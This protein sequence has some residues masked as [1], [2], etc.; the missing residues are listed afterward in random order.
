MHIPVDHWQTLDAHF[1]DKCVIKPLLSER[2]TGT[3][4]CQSLLRHACCFD[5]TSLL[6]GTRR[7][8]VKTAR[9]RQFRLLTRLFENIGAALPS[10]LA[11]NSAG[12]LRLR[13][14]LDLNTSCTASVLSIGAYPSLPR[15]S[16]IA[17]LHDKSHMRLASC[18][19]RAHCLQDHDS[20][21]AL[22]P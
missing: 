10:D 16:L 19:N 4:V 2:I 1:L 13:A 14:D 5:T 21:Q 8:P 20:Q 7:T 6:P 22:H 12:R 11:M 3:I 17:L 15:D 18:R 9:K